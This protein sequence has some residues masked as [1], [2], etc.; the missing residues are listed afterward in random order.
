MKFISNILEKL[1]ER[2]QSGLVFELAGGLLLAI[3]LVGGES[4]SLRIAG[5]GV[6]AALLAAGLLLRMDGGFG[7]LREASFFA[8]LTAPFFTLVMIRSIGLDFWS[9][10]LLT[11]KGYALALP[12][13]TS[14][15]VSVAS[16]PTFANLL[17]NLALR[18]SGNPSLAALLED[19]ARIR[20]VNLFWAAASLALLYLVGRRMAGIRAGFLAVIALATTIPFFNFASSVGGYSLQMLLAG[21]LLYCWLSFEERPAWPS[22]AVVGLTAALMVWTQFSTLYFLAAI[23]VYALLSV[24]TLGSGREPGGM[25]RIPQTRLVMLI[26]GGA[27]VG[28]LVNVLLTLPEARTVGADWLDAQTLT[29]QLPRVLDHFISTR[30]LMILAAAGGWFLAARRAKQEGEGRLLEHLGYLAVLLVL[31]FLFRFAYGDPSA[32][33][34]LLVLLPVFALL[35]GLGLDAFVLWLPRKWHKT[36]LALLAVGLYAC[37]AFYAEVNRVEAGL[38]EDLDQGRQSQTLY[39]NYYQAFFNPR[40]LLREYQAVGVREDMPLQIIDMGD[41]AALTYLDW[42]QIPYRKLGGLADLQL[43]VAGSLDILT[44]FPGLFDG[45]LKSAYPALECS[46]LNRELGYQN[47]YHCTCH[48]GDGK[49][50]PP[51]R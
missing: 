38:R 45:R 34:E 18:F 5:M 21:L 50:C 47:I 8:L 43:G 44:A 14:A 41:D 3:C 30:F 4:G 28:A 23:A 6:G 11:L 20:V 17:E 42:L 13:K 29:D 32:D 27:L 25:L 26:L 36:W 49:G 12:W 39:S 7:F 10:E 46:R 33:R 35:V 19:P 51:E 24:V 15:A 1:P 48:E 31:P 2:K 37:G 40:N 16:N 9:G 22:G